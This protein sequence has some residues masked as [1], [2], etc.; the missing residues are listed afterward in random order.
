[1]WIGSVE[2]DLSPQHAPTNLWHARA[3]NCDSRS[4]PR[5]LSNRGTDSSQ[6]E[7]SG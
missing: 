4:V 3:Q 6:A 1:M 2:M 5:L 7:S